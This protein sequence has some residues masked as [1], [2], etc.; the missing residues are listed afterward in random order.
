MRDTGSRIRAAFTLIETLTVLML[1]AIA[2]ASF[3]TGLNASD[4]NGRFHSAI[5][6]IQRLD[7]QARQLARTSGD[8]VTLVFANWYETS[9]ARVVCVVDEDRQVA[10]RT[11]LPTPMR[12]DVTPRRFNRRIFIDRSGR[13]VDYELELEWR[14]RHARWRVFG[15]TGATVPITEDQQ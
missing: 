10:L 12:L 3:A 11:T 6:S 14:E 13:S 9:E 8:G 2:F 4:V 1:L 15:L 5:A 7:R